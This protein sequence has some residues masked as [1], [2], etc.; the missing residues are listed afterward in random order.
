VHEP[1]AM[2]IGGA[3][4]VCAQIYAVRKNRTGNERAQRHET[5]QGTGRTVRLRVHDVRHV[6]RDMN[7]KNGLKITR[8]I[9]RLADGVVADREARMQA[10]QA[11]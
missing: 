11:T 3:N 1:A 5:L 4:L 6:L 8:E 2:S 7:V 10:D 9:S